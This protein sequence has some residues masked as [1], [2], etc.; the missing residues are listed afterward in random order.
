MAAC[1][2]KGGV[3]LDVVR[4]QGVLC[5]GR[6]ARSEALAPPTAEPLDAARC[7]AGSRIM[8]GVGMT[9][10]E[11]AAICRLL[12][13]ASLEVR[14]TE[15]GRR[16]RGTCSCGYATTTRNTVVDAAQ[17]LRHHLVLVV[18]E[19]RESGVSLPSSAASGL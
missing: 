19:A 14:P 1:R 12:G 13:H 4:G 15:S 9:N 3:P 6:G 2:V 11:R 17:A 16:F 8:A 18:R 7:R 5:D 10:Q